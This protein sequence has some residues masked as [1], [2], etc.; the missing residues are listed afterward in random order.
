M[1]RSIHR[2]NCQCLLMTMS[3]SDSLLNSDIVALIVYAS[4][5]HVMRLLALIALRLCFNRIITSF[6]RIFITLLL[7]N[8]VNH[9]SIRER[10]KPLH[11][12]SAR[13]LIELKD[14]SV[15]TAANKKPLAVNLIKSNKVLIG[16][17]DSAVAN[18]STDPRLE[19]INME[20][21]FQS[22]DWS[23]RCDKW[24]DIKVVLSRLLH[25][26]LNARTMDDSNNS[27]RIVTCYLWTTLCFLLTHCFHVISIILSVL[28]FQRFVF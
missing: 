6:I 24:C 20:E 18:V 1:Q 3:Q 28:I 14:P 27:V 4:V 8:N 17:N 10:E 16:S 15:L 21:T 25:T 7:R 19:V 23:Y 26:H 11:Y 2:G 12:S 13:C 22:A 5:V 9:V